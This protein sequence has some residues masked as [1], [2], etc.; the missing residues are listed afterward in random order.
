MYSED[1]GDI[2]LRGQHICHQVHGQSF[3]NVFEGT[4][5]G[6]APVLGSEGATGPSPQLGD[7]LN[8]VSLLPP[9]PCSSD[10]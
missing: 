5:H 4:T 8:V 3:G 7:F 10:V 6:E 2:R 1:A 9:A